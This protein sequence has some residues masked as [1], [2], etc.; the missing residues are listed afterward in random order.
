M[1]ILRDAV[2]GGKSKQDWDTYRDWST[3]RKTVRSTG[4]ARPPL[5]VPADLQSAVKNRPIRSAGYVHPPLGV[6]ADLQS[7]VKK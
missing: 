4:Y 6:P 2:G 1:P 7:A 5:G 3:K